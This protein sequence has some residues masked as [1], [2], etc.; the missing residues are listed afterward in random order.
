VLVGTAHRLRGNLVDAVRAL[1]FAERTPAD[2]VTYG[3]TI[4]CRAALELALGR[5]EEALQTSVA[6]EAGLERF[7][8]RDYPIIRWRLVAAQAA[9]ELGRIDEAIEHADAAIFL[10]RPTRSAM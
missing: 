10:A 4:A 5:P 6:A 8:L 9:G 3:I 1:A 2:D 7:E